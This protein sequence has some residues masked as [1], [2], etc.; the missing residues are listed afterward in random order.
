M[1][2]ERLRNTV[3]LNLFADLKFDG[4]GR[5]VNISRTTSIF[6]SLCTKQYQLINLLPTTSMVLRRMTKKNT[7]KINLFKEKKKHLQLNM[8]KVALSEI[9]YEVLVNE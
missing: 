5:T 4:L 1:N 9:T 6:I 8:I 2:H 3:L 7:V